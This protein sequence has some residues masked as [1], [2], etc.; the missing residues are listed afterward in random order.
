MRNLFAG[1]RD[2]WQAQRLLFRKGLWP[3]FLIPGVISALYFPFSI[4]VALYFLGDAA[5]FVHDNWLPAFLQGAVTMWMLAIFMWCAGMYLGFL[6]FRNI[7]MIL[8]SPVLSYLSEAA[9]DRKLGK[10]RPGFDWKEALHSAGRGT[11]MSLVTLGLALVA[12]LL[13]WLIALVPV[14]G[15]LLA[16]I[17]MP[18][19]QCFLAGLGFC[20]PPLERRGTSIRGTFRHAWCHRGRTIG[21][22]AA[23]TALLFIP[24][25]GWFLAPS[26]G[27]VAGTLAVVDLECEAK[28]S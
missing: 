1:F 9:E 10:D 5:G 11:A 24:L 28:A 21:Q 8:Y 14:I 12:L 16:I 26:Y 6:L 2:Y 4:L 3:L 13:S 15:G 18:L 27:I 19:V 20:D 17:L 7:V 23:F 22:G 25:A